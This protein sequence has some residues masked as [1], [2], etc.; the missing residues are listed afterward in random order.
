MTVLSPRTAALLLAWGT[1]LGT[2]LA[3][4]QGDTPPGQPT[5]TKTPQAATDLAGTRWQLVE[6]Q[7]MDDSVYTPDDPGKYTLA[8]GEDRVSLRIDCNRGV[9]P[10][11][12]E[13][14]SQLVFGPLAVTKALCAPPSLHDR[15]LMDLG[16]VRSYVLKDGQLFLATMADGSILHFAPLATEE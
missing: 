1:G 12:S 4:P 6:I 14:P 7:S 10:W 13:G 11:S 15:F 2:A 16:F 5:A 9:G 3:A 8:F